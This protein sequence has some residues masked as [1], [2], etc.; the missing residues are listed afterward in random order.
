MNQTLS[1]GPLNSMHIML[2]DL[3]PKVSYFYVALRLFLTI[4]I[5][6]TFKVTHSFLQK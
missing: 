2:L 1:V 5:V 4:Y 3:F 6:F